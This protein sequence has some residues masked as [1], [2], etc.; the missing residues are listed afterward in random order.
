MKSLVYIDLLQKVPEF[1]PR[2]Q[3]LMNT[4]PSLLH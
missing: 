4:T 2:D 3:T 1:L